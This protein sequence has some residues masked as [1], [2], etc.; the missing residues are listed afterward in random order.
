MQSNYFLTMKQYYFFS[1]T[2]ASWSFLPQSQKLIWNKLKFTLQGYA[3]CKA[4]TEHLILPSIY[5]KYQ[6]FFQPI[7]TELEYKLYKRKTYCPL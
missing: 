2:R 4:T 6:D 1:A 5:A 7:P 3:G